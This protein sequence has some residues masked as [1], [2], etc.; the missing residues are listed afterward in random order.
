MLPRNWKIGSRLKQAALAFDRGVNIAGDATIAMSARFETG[1]GGAIRVGARCQ[2]MPCA[3]LLAYGG[4]I[5]L[6]HAP[7]G[8][9]G[10]VNACRRRGRKG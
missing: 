5:E 2:I 10:A 9:L 6:G 4:R 3:M 8:R 7:P 1:P